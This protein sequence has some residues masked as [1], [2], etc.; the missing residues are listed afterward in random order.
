MP[1]ATLSLLALASATSCGGLA[2]DAPVPV[3]MSVRIP[4]ITLDRLDSNLHLRIFE[5][6]GDLGCDTASGRITGADPYATIA[7]R[8]ISPNERCD[9][10]RW[11][12]LRM[13]NGEAT[14]TDL[15]F[16]KTGGLQTVRVPGGKTY[17]VLIEG[18]GSVAA[19][20]GGMQTITLGSGCREVSTMAGQTVGVSIELQE[21]ADLGR[22]G[23]M[24]VSSGEVCDEG[25]AT[26]TCNAR[27]RIPVQDVATTAVGPKFNPS[28]AWA[29]SQN[30]LIGFHT[31]G[32]P[33]N[34]YLRM[35]NPSGFPITSPAVLA[36]DNELDA[37]ARSE[38]LNV[39]VAASAT[40]FAA[41]WQTFESTTTFD[42][43]ANISATYEAPTPQQLL[44]N[45]TTTGAAAN[46]RINPAV[47]IN[48]TRAL[49]VFENADGASL[50]VASSMVAATP[51]APTADTAL[52]MAGP[53][54]AE[55]REPVV[56]ALTDGT[57][58]AAWTSGGTGSRDIFAVKLNALGVAMG[59]PVMVNSQTTSDQD[60]VAVGTNGTTVVFAWRD[61]SGGDPMD[62]SGSTVRW[63]TFDASLSPMG[64]DRLAPV[65]VEG[66]Q[67]RPTV[68]LST[69][70]TVLIAWEHAG[71]FIRGRLFRPD[72]S[73]VVNRF[74]GSTGDF[75][76]NASADENAPAG[77]M[78]ARP[79]AAFGGTNRFAV[80]WRDGVAAGIRLRVF[81]E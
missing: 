35:M 7:G 29:P 30:L 59:T 3:G 16:P 58:V 12:Q 50:R 20:G 37:M 75:E 14:P 53:G 77:G 65:T 46:G 52:V 19:A 40:G 38:Q 17:L 54:S 62:T 5:K 13:A 69:A 6:T 15:C 45:A 39:R 25:M 70:G 23:D 31:T 57:F 73:L 60:Q 49:F 21:Q 47:A 11:N 24:R 36:R 79:A 43:N 1:R 64:T 22:C 55:M 48:A 51:V 76:V 33:D 27:C 66:D 81:I 78:R 26:P 68:A 63:R 72:G 42:I 67:A 4:Q 71:G 44:I 34:P 9:P 41:V 32:S 74:S 8:S 56:A 61:T 10:T 80:A 28:I 18:S 2:L